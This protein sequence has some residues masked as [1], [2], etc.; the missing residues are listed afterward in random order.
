MAVLFGLLGLPAE[1]VRAI[2]AWKELGLALLVLLPLLLLA[3]AAIMP[4]PLIICRDHHRHALRL[5]D[6]SVGFA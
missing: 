3:I 2:A 5:H 1:T 4:L 6:V